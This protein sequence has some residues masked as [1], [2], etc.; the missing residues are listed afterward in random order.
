MPFSSN[1]AAPPSQ[2]GYWRGAMDWPNTKGAGP[3]V[4]STANIPGWSTTATPG[5]NAGF[6]P[7]VGYI[8]VFTVIELFILHHLTVF[9]KA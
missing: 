9:L 7:T 6:S 4:P 3:K 1:Q 8:F 2:T 5:Y